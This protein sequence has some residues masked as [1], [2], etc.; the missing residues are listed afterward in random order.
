MQHKKQL[1]TK[2]PVTII[3]WIGFGFATLEFVIQMIAGS[4][5]VVVGAIG[6]TITCAVLI[7]IILLVIGI[8]A[9]IL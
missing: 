1:Y 9:V 2:K 7:G 3:D 6:S 5:L 4:C 8:I